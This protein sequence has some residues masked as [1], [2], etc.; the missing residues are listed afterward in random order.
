MQARKA[1]FGGLMLALCLGLSFLESL[2]PALPYLPPGFKLGLANFCVL[3][4]LVWGKP[5]FAYFLVVAKAGLAFLTGGVSSF[6]FSCCGGLAACF[7]MWAIFRFTKWPEATASMSGAVVNN[8]VQTAL[9]AFLYKSMFVLSYVFLI[10][11]AA[12]V[13][14][15]LI[16]WLCHTANPYLIRIRKEFR[17]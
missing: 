7:V 15:L 5:R 10:I 14:G 4:C 2:L 17:L 16:G 12:L 8:L 11:P 9:A 3:L 6:L 1:A 13:S